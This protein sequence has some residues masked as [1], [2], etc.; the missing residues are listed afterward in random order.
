MTFFEEELQKILSYCSALKKPQYIGNR[1]Y[2][3]IG[4]DLRARI[5]LFTDGGN[6]SGIRVIILNRTLGE[7][8]AICLR[9]RDI[10]GLRKVTNPYFRDGVSPH[11][12]VLDGVPEWY[13]FHPA[14]VDYINFSESIEKYISVFQEDI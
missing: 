1:C 5:E 12:A 8:D 13:V 9:F 4:K 7:V 14:E 6:Y 3:T 2:G 11:I 10:W